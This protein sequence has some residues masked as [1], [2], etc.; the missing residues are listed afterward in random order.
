M[1]RFATYNFKNFCFDFSWLGSLDD[2]NG[3][4]SE[5]YKIM[6]S[7]KFS[8]KNLKLILDPDQKD[9]LE[10]SL[11]RFGISDNVDREFVL[12]HIDRIVS[13]VSV[14]DVWH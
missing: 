14:N 4:F 10:F 11:E 1:K 3:K 7:K 8:G 9:M 2:G 5:K 13:G 6:K 12:K